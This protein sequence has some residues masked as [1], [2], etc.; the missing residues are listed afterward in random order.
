MNDHDA[1]PRTGRVEYPD[2]LARPK[3]SSHRHSR[4][5]TTVLTLGDAGESP[6]VENVLF[7]LYR[8]FVN[9][10][11]GWK[12]DVLHMDPTSVQ[13]SVS[14]RFARQAR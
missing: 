5:D 12:G 8:Q 13:M 4:Q 2:V 10:W 11:K 7:L 1:Q 9:K 14:V 6:K 3:W